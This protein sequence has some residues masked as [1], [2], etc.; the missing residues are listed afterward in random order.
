MFYHDWNLSSIKLP[1]GT[2][3]PNRDY[4][5]RL[6]KWGRILPMLAA[7][8][9]RP[10]ARRFRWRHV[11]ILLERV[12]CS[13]RNDLRRYRIAQDRCASL[14]ARQQMIVDSVLNP[15][16]V[17]KLVGARRWKSPLSLRN[18]FWSERPSARR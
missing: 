5:R 2:T 18:G 6:A 11:G 9:D 16:F 17:E 3:P 13:S 1:D 8:I 14:E 10:F 15:A 12:L 4:V 7:L